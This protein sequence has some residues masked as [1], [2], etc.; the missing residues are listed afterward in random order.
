MD[1]S[2]VADIF[3]HTSCINNLDLNLALSILLLGFLDWLN[4]WC[5]Q[6]LNMFYL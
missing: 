5:S 1:G 4:Y 3:I 6:W 2:S